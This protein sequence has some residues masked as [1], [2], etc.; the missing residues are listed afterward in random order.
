MICVSCEKDAPRLSLRPCRLC[1]LHY[2]KDCIVDDICKDCR[3]GD[4][5]EM[6]GDWDEDP[7]DED[8]ADDDPADAWLDPDEPDVD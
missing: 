1:N 8:S 7:E 2:C 3:A 5:D 4:L 6:V